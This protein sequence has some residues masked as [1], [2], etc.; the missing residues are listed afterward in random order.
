MDITTNIQ[1]VNSDLQKYITTALLYNIQYKKWNKQIVEFISSISSKD[2]HDITQY[3]ATNNCYSDSS[4]T[5]EPK[6]THYD[7]NKPNMYILIGL[8]GSGKSTFR[9]NLNKVHHYNII[10]RDD[11]IVQRYQ[12][13]VL[14]STNYHE[15]YSKC[16]ELSINDTNCNDDFVSFYQHEL[17]KKQ[18]VII[19][20]T[21][22]TIKTRKKW[23]V[24]ADKYGYNIVMIW[25]NR[26]VEQCINSQTGRDKQISDQT[27]LNM[28]EQLTPPVIFHECHEIFII[29]H[30]DNFTN[31]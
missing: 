15:L 18:D 17:S 27:I 4:I 7:S 9:Y 16:W 5:I 23:S 30:V 2:V 21:N 19:D 22:L 6:Y 1:A 24:Y 20:M 29:N 25:L 26:N 10:S 3:I 31:N 13:L 11:F 12:H 28:F 8:P 14:D